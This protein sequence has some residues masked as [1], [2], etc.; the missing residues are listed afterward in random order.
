MDFCVK[1]QALVFSLLL[2]MKPNSLFFYKCKYYSL[3]PFPRPNKGNRS[4]SWRPITTWGELT[5]TYSVLPSWVGDMHWHTFLKWMDCICSERPFSFLSTWT[6]A[7]LQSRGGRGKVYT[8]EVWGWGCRQE[9]LPR[10]WVVFFNHFPIIKLAFKSL[11]LLLVQ[12][13]NYFYEH[14]KGREGYYL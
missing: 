5:R 2:T 13:L 10:P 7:K 12:F 9:R 11:F 14:T 1:K 4:F 3:G 8:E 6:D